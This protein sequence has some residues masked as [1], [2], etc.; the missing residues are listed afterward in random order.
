MPRVS[1]KGMTWDHSRGYDPLV[2]CSKRYLAEC[3]INIEWHKRTLKDFGDQSLEDLANQYDLLVID[4]P[5][6]GVS[7]ETNCVIPLDQYINQERLDILRDQTAGPSFDSYNYSGHQWAL[8]VDAAMQCAAYRADLLSGAVPNTWDQVLATKD[9]GM[10]L[11]PTD[12]LCS[13][14]SLSAQLGAP[15]REENTYLIAEPKG[16]EVLALMKSLC[17]AAHPKSTELNPIQLFDL[18]AQSDEISYS[19]MAFCYTNYSRKGYRENLLTFADVPSLK[20]FL[21]RDSGIKMFSSVLGGAGIAVSSKCQNKQMAC[22]FALWIC[23]KEI[24]SS[25]YTINAG[26]PGNGEAWQNAA[27]NNLTNN[28]FRN[29][30]HTLDSAYVRPRFSAWPHFQ[31]H[32]GNIVHEYLVGNINPTTVIRYLNQ[33]FAKC[34]HR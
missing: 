15:I 3:G 27:T 32:L 33:Q 25:V 21:Q 31:E 20:P 29:T 17:T 11:C 7:A 16:L 5:H 34:Q 23:G 12:S 2:A 6:S 8:P 19:P 26:Q 22:D 1:L 30:I 13:F 18:M 4:H 14:L 9:L 28:F 10:A 24:Q